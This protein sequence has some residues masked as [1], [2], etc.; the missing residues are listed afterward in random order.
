VHNKSANSAGYHTLVC[1]LKR[2][3]KRLGSLTWWLCT[4]RCQTKPSTCVSFPLPITHSCATPQRRPAN[5]R[6]RRPATTTQPPTPWPT[7]GPTSCWSHPFGL[8]FMLSPPDFMSVPLPFF[9]LGFLGISYTVFLS[10]SNCIFICIL[11]IFSSQNA[12]RTYIFV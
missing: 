2:P 8:D 5:P 10:Y 1:S 12:P 9:L 11:C 3:H 7:P 6:Q 4:R